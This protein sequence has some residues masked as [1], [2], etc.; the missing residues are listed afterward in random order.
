MGVGGAGHARR[1]ETEL[2]AKVK[3]A[4]AAGLFQRP[5]T[6]SLHSAIRY[7]PMTDSA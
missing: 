1:Q 6:C 7:V 4:A 5:F 2:V 3:V